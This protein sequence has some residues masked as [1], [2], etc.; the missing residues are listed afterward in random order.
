MFLSSEISFYWAWWLCFAAIA[1]CGPRW[2]GWLGIPAAAVLIA[3]LIVA[4]EF[5]SVSQDM[6]LYPNSGRDID[7]PFLFG[8]IFRII[9]Y[10]A[11]VV[12]FGILGAKLRSRKARAARDAKV[13]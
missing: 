1:F 4:I 13:A 10:N 7:F 8:V 5:H 9:F 11:T 12:P 3:G 2:I 6:R